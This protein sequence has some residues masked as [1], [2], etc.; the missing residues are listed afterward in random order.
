MLITRCPHCET[1][2]RIQAAHLEQAEG[3]VR[4]GRC[5]NVFDA[6]QEL[7]QSLSPTLTDLAETNTGTAVANP[8]RPTDPDMRFSEAE[9]DELERTLE[10]SEAGADA[11]TEAPDLSAAPTVT[12]EETAAPIEVPAAPEQ[13]PKESQAN[14][15]LEFNLPADQWEDFF[16]DTIV[17]E[18]DVPSIS[19]TGVEWVVLG[20]VETPGPQDNTGAAE[21]DASDGAEKTE[22][23]PGTEDEAGVS[24]AEAT[25][26]GHVMDLTPL[27]A[28]P[29]QTQA[30]PDR[31]ELSQAGATPETAGPSPGEALDPDEASL[32][33]AFFGELE[34]AH[35]NEPPPTNYWHGAAAL[36]LVA[37]LGAQY[38]HYNR[39]TL[40][41]HSSIGPRIVA[42]YQRVGI[43]LSPAWD[44]EQYQINRWV[45]ASDTSDEGKA[46]LKITAQITNRGPKPQPFPLIQLALKDRWDETVA[47]R[48]F[49]PTE[50]LADPT[51]TTLL[52]AG[53][54]V[55]AQLKVLDPGQDAYGF[56]LDVCI[57]SHSEQLRCANE[58]QRR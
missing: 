32:K 39:Q 40:A 29:P 34:E 4:C 1:A 23:D 21:P 13:T 24:A 30:Q 45:A 36:L 37:G 58:P 9:V 19:D 25:P 56:E 11:V 52:A 49:E 51:T 17:G 46:S 28:A 55:Q 54:H 5:A 16:S 8:D 53:E 22:A 7:R 2:F 20:E 27:A 43:E 50:Y 44:L 15:R 14:E 48:I 42:S 10:A 31:E 38:V 26:D 41:T 35:L 12:E 3:H 57:R 6:Y 33:E 47:G 18:G